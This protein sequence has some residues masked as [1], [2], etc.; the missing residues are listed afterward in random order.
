MIT[1]FLLIFIIIFVKKSLTLNRINYV[2]GDA[3]NPQGEGIKIIVHVCNNVGKWGAGFVLALSKKWSEPEKEYRSKPTH[4]L[5][6]IQI[7]PVDNNI[8]VINMIAQ[9]DV[10]S[11]DNP[12]P[13]KYP[14][15]TECL[16]QVNAFAKQINGTIH[17]P[18][19]GSG[20]AGGDWN[21]IEKIIE[22]SIEVPVT[23][24][25]L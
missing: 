22:E 20:L 15:L 7:V 2:K 21:V 3:T 19:I 9:H 25:D 11:Y 12:K 13:I 6:D 5:G 17:M 4:S 18:R 24:Y 16:K 8:L 23:V 10:R 14:Y 1:L